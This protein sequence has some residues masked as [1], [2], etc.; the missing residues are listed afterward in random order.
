MSKQQARLRVHTGEGIKEI[1]LAI[2]QNILDAALS[3][4]V[5]LDHACGGVCACSTCH[6]KIKNAREC[7]SEASE[8]EEDQLDEAR[9][10]SLESRLGCQATLERVP[11]DGV[12]EIAIPTWNV[13]AVQ[14]GH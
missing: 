4:G 14:E 7:F 12:V 13:N 10:V 1:T 2:G 6:V 9:D 5:D 8:D 3:Q 11:A